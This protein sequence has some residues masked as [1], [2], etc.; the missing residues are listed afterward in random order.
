[1]ESSLDK[2]VE[3]L[4]KKKLFAQSLVASLLNVHTGMKGDCAANGIEGAFQKGFS[5]LFMVLKCILLKCVMLVMLPK[6]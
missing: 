6:R 3:K 4:G 5:S 1:M 2:K